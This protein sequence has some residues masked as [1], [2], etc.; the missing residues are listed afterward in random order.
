MNILIIDDDKLTITALQHSL[1]ELGHHAEVAKDGEAAIDMV[2]KGNFDLIISDIM[3]PGISGLSLVNVLRSVH[4][5][6]VPII[7]MSSLNNRPLL[8]AAMKAGANDF[9][10]KPVSIAEL[11]EKIKK[12][13]MTKS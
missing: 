1:S 6:F 13:E 10:D 4:L 7:M 5:C 8:D 12:F 11:S 2:T 9:I 3:M